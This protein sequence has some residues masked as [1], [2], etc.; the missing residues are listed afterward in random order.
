M[1]DE[2]FK[3]KQEEKEVL[4]LQSKVKSMM[5]S[6]EVPLSIVSTTDKLEDLLNKRVKVLFSSIN[7]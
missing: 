4:A 7:T 6:K 1:I 2:P 5:A 3:D